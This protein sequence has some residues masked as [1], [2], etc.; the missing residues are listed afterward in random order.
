M[1]SCSKFELISPFNCKLT[2]VFA[3]FLRR[4]AGRRK[5]CTPYGCEIPNNPD[6]IMIWKEGFQKECI[7]RRDLIAFGRRTKPNRN[8]SCL[9]PV[10][11]REYDKI[12]RSRESVD[13]ALEFNEC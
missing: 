13:A 8:R 11:E 12:L 4:V 6:L 7:V 9:R 1:F 2:E 5:S 3:Y 10:A